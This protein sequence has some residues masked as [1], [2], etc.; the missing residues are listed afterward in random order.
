MRQ[1]CTPTDVR[2]QHSAG[3]LLSRGILHGRTPTKALMGGPLI[4]RWRLR[5]RFAETEIVGK[6]C[7]E[8]AR[9]GE[10]CRIVLMTA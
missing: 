7:P 6:G 10:M 2:R 4:R 8:V 9:L 5:Q 3:K 1:E